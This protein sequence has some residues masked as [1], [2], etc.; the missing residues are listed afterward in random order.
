MYKVTVYMVD[1]SLDSYVGGEPKITY[2]KN[3]K[4]GLYEYGTSKV[5]HMFYTLTDLNVNKV[6]L[7]GCV[8]R[9]IN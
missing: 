3:E 4:T 1:D 5:G 8:P 7:V 2:G 9:T 6:S